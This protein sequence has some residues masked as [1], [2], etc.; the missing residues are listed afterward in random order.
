MKK[1]VFLRRRKEK[2]NIEQTSKINRENR[3]KR[4]L[5]KWKEERR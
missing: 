1:K 2:V 5:L 4:W 3:G